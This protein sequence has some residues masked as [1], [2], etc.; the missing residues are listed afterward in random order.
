MLLTVVAFFS[1]IAFMAVGVT[2]F[3]IYRSY[4]DDLK[5][6]D[7]VIR[8]SAIGQSTVFDRTG[9]TQLYEFVDQSG[10]IRNPT[11]LSEISPYVIAATIATEDASFYDNPG[12]NFRGLARAAIENFTPF[13][14]GFLAGSGGSSITQQLA[15]NIYIEYDERTSRRVERKLKETVIAL[16]LKRNYEDNQILEWY[17]N[18]VFYGNNAYGI[19]AAAERYFNKDAKDLTLAESALLAGLPQAPT[20]YDPSIEEQ[21]P[22][23]KGRQITVLNL[24]AEHIEQINAIPGLED[25]NVPLINITPEEIEAARTEELNYVTPE[26]TIVAPHFVFYVGE[27]VQDMCAAGLFEAPNDLPCD[28]VVDQGG[29]RITTTIDLGLQAIG[30]QVVEENI[31]ANEERYGGHNGSLVAVRPA[32]GEIIAYV[33]SR[34]YTRADIEGKVDIA[35]SLQSHG[36]TMKVFSYLAAFE[37]GAVPSTFV[38]DEPLFLETAAGKKQVN[39]WNFSHLGNITMRKALS[40]SVNTA[41][42]RT[43][44]AVG[45]SHYRELAH[46]MGI[47]DLQTADCGPTITL[48]ACEVQLVDMTFAYSVLANNGTMRGMP[49]VEDLPDGYRPLDPVPVLKIEDDSGNIVFQYSQPTEQQVVDPAHAYMITDVLSKDA[50]TWSRLTLDRPAASKTGTSEEFRDGVLMGYTPDIAAGVWMGNADNTPMA[51]GTFSSAGS[52]PMWRD[53]ML[54]AHEYYALPPS[55]FTA[56]E[57]VATSPCGGR[58]EVFKEGQAPSKPGACKAPSGGGG[59]APTGSPTPTPRGPVFPTRVFGTPT[60]TPTPE[61][62]PAPPEESPIIF[63][64]TVKTGDT[65]DGIAQKFGVSVLDIIAYNDV[66]EDEQLHSGDVLKIPLSGNVD[67]NEN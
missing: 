46:R 45:D 15:K 5:P 4:A 37:D 6:P 44:M 39:N 50:I 12:V 9:E 55:E 11:P 62:T 53:F 14:P 67:I 49:T 51:P 32:T 48:G 40:E 22:D 57:S 66:D 54:R 23:A 59:P 63:F 64:Y 16:E 17:L 10:E 8:E 19:Q 33:G 1:L 60:P 34:D 7:E 24:M 36:S 27:V 58:T 29:L 21:R 35:T 18:Q 26:T 3:V 38:Q 43:M 2:G 61:P 28:R 31:A 20:D 13:G 30:E 65:L 56:P 42:V 25:P 52:G 47:T 41:A